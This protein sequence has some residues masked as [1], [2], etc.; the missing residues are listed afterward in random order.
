MPTQSFAAT[1]DWKYENGTL[2]NSEDSSVV[3]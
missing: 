2:I 3:I 1:N